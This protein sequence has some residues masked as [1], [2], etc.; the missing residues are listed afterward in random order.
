MSKK[1]FTRLTDA[2]THEKIRSIL[3][4]LKPMMAYSFTKRHNLIELKNLSNLLQI[5]YWEKLKN[6]IESIDL[7]YSGNTSSPFILTLFIG[8]NDTFQKQEQYD[9]DLVNIA[10]ETE[11]KTSYFRSQWHHLKDENNK[12]VS[13]KISNSL[14]VNKKNLKDKTYNTFLNQRSCSFSF[15]QYKN[16]RP[17]F[18]KFHGESFRNLKI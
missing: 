4:Q 12:R 1:K 6:N 3:S 18:Y 11:S 8:R 14:I 2:F 13:Y 17:D 10:A 9:I 15:N 5:N 7:I 16:I